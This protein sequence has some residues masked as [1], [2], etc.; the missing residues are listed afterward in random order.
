MS[1]EG[2]GAPVGGE[3]GCGDGG[4][5]VED[6]ARLGCEESK[7]DVSES[8]PFGVMERTKSRWDE[9]GLVRGSAG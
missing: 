1:D 3:W 8:F 9:K 5:V 6:A 2:E 7:R 4:G